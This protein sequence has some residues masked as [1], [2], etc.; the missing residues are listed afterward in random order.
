MFKKANFDE[1]LPKK[2]KTYI[3][4]AQKSNHF[5]IIFGL[6]VKQLRLERK[7]SFADFSKESGMSVSYLNEIEKG[8]K[9]PKEDKIR[10][11]AKVLHVTY[12]ELVS[13]ELKYALAPV[14]ELLRSNFLNELPLDLFGIE[15]S[16]VVG[17]IANAPMRV[18]AFISTLVELS[19]NYAV[20]EENF[21]FSAM[22]AY[23]ELHYNYFEDIEQAALDFSVQH[24]LPTDGAVPVELLAGVLTKTYD[25]DIVLDGLD[26]HKDLTK[27]RSVYVPK[28]KKLLLNGRINEIQRAFQYGKELGFNYLNLEERPLGSTLLRVHSFEEVINNFKAAYFSV[29]ILINHQAFKKN[30]ETF[31]EK[32]KWDGQFLLDL[33]EHYQASPGMIFQRFN[34]LPKYFGIPKSFFQRFIHHVDVDK[35]KIDKE[36]HLNHQHRPHANGLEEHYCRRWSSLSLLKDMQTIK[37]NGKFDG[38]ITGIQ[39]A[40][41]FGT[42][43][44]YLC[45]TIARPGYPTPKRNVSVTLG[46]QIDD[47]LKQKI[48][49]VDDP[50]IPVV[51]VNITC[52][53]CS[54]MDCKERVAP[55]IV[56]QNKAQRQRVLEALKNVVE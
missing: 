53:R 23:Q 37:K 41:Y 50:D 9:Y 49:F 20:R 14:G 31:F 10:I 2:I 28:T 16:K 54:I 3:F 38:P 13:Q 33:M 24:N 11:L 43:D 44:E 12:E 21:Y 32:E 36:L 8:K 42:D 46:F 18:G 39:R 47:D 22:R 56:I 55:P 52:E 51:E 6:K 17:I 40:R 4:M 34:I 48:K 19:R 35:F 5:K 25:Y 45:F 27:L 30:L 15:M 29:A 7:L 26:E 1:L